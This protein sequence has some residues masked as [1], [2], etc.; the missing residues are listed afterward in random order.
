MTGRDQLALKTGK[1]K[2][3]YVAKPPEAE[4]PGA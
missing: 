3:D 4:P 2:E 1:K